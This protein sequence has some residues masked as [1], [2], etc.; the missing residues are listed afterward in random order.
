MPLIDLNFTRSVT[1]APYVGEDRFGKR[2]YGPAVVVPAIIT[3]LVKDIKDFR[4][5]T[6]IADAWVAIPPEY[7]VGER[8]KITLPNGASPFI[9]SISQIFDEEA[10]EYLYTEIYIGKVAPGEGSL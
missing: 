9:G 6:F 1:I 3:W 2:T 5:N 10:E 4:G 7:A 8:D